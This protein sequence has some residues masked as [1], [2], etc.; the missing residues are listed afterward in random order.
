MMKIC[1]YICNRFVSSDINILFNGWTFVL[2]YY[3]LIVVVLESRY[4]NNLQKKFADNTQTHTHTHVLFILDINIWY[5]MMCRF[6]GTFW[7]K[8]CMCT[9]LYKKSFWCFVS[10]VYE[11]EL[12]LFLSNFYKTDKKLIGAVFFYFIK[13]KQ[14]KIVLKAG[15]WKLK[16]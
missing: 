12:M 1:L 3:I 16:L 15:H 10:D 6:N 4:K 7:M 2:Y 9:Y 11:D 14:P 13:K 5:D 8:N